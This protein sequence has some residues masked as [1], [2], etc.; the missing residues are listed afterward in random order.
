MNEIWKD[1]Q[2]FEGRYQVSNMGRIKRLPVQMISPKGSIYT[3]G[4]R[5]LQP[6]S[7]GG[8]YIHIHLCYGDGRKITRT[9]HRLV[10]T[11]F[12]DGY[13]KGL[14]VNHINEDKTDNRASNLEWCTN[15]YNLNYSDIC[16]WKRRTVYQYDMDGN[17]IKSFR[18]CH[19]AAR[20]V[21]C[22]ESGLKH[23]LYESKT[24]I[25]NGYRWSFKKRTKKWWQNIAHT[26]RT[27]TVPVAQYSMDGIYLNTFPSIK[28]AAIHVGV[29]RCAIGNC[30]KGKTKT[31]GGYI[32]RIAK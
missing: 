4:E 26:Y 24:G 6:N 5:I 31:S 15:K 9:I 1:I 21:G 27:H 13:K 14:V 8:R 29:S 19:E 20:E 3:L 7:S 16:D 17:Y 12:V 25:S 10:A 30:C 22:K 11:H 23:A 32:W 2:G 18:C 28:I